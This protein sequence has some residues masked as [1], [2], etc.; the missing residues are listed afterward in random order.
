MDFR[1]ALQTDMGEPQKEVQGFLISSEFLHPSF[2]SFS[3]QLVFNSCSLSVDVLN[4]WCV[5]GIKCRLTGQ[6]TSME[7]HLSGAEAW[8]KFTVT[9]ATRIRGQILKASLKHNS[10]WCPWVFFLRKDCFGWSANTADEVLSSLFSVGRWMTTVLTRTWLKESYRM[11]SACSWWMTWFSQSP[12]IPM[13]LRTACD[14][15]N[16][17]L[18]LFKERILFTTWCILGQVRTLELKQIQSPHS[19][20]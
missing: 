9:L 4:L 13:S 12:W 18:I 6:W 8:P 20:T 11:P 3:P 7:T 2:S 19:G 15:P 17:W 16:W 10:Q 5:K 1:M 14:F